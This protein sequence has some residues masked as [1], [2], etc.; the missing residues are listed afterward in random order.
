[1]PI[2]LNARPLWLA[3]GIAN[4]SA[5]VLIAL[6]PAQSFDVGMVAQWCRDWFIHGVN[7]Y[8][9]PDF[10]TNYPPYALVFL[11]PLA[12]VPQH[13]LKGTWAIVSV[14]LAALAGWLGMRVTPFQDSGNHKVRL[15]VGVFLAWESLR[16]GLGLGQF[17]LLALVSGLGG[18]LSQQD[19]TRI[20]LGIAMIKP[21][22]G[23]AFTVGDSRRIG[24][25]CLDCSGA[26]K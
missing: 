25:R 4:V 14:A 21:Q 8:R 19:G 7:P 15:S 18:R 5:G 9:G 17:T 23:V 2:A 10:R 11:S 16:V 22:V 1:M 20:L 12:I 3:L 6:R 26:D 13:L 24:D